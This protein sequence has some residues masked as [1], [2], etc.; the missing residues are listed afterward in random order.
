MSADDTIN[1]QDNVLGGK[2]SDTI[3]GGGGNDRLD[4]DDDINSDVGDD[5]IDG[6]LG[7][8]TLLGSGGNDRLL[9]GAGDDDLSGENGNDRL[10]GGDGIDELDGGNDDD[11]VLG[12]A[13]NDTASGYAGNDVVIGDEGDG[14]SSTATT[15][16]STTRA[17]PT[18]TTPSTA[19]RATTPSTAWRQRPCE[20]WHG[21]RHAERRLRRRHARRRGRGQRQHRRGGFG[22]D[23]LRGG[24]GDDRLTGRA[25]NDDLDG[26]DGNDILGGDSVRYTNLTPPTFPSGAYRVQPRWDLNIGGDDTYDG[27]TGDDFIY[28]V[29]LDPES[30]ASRQNLTVT[31]TDPAD[32]GTSTGTVVDYLYSPATGYQGD[33]QIGFQIKLN[34]SVVNTGTM[35]ISNGQN[36]APVAVDDTAI[37]DRGLA[38]QGNVL[39]NDTDPDGDLL[40]IV[41][42]SGTTS[43][44]TF[45]VVTGGGFTY[46]PSTSFAGATDSFTY[47]VVDPDGATDT[48]TVTVAIRPDYTAPVVACERPTDWSRTEWTVD[49]IAADLASGLADPTRASFELSSALGA[50]NEGPTP[51]DPPVVCDTAGNC[52][53]LEPFDVLVDRK[54]PTI[55]SA[56][57]G[58]TYGLDAEV[59]RE[60]TRTDAGSGLANECYGNGLPLD[61]STAGVHTFIVGA[62]DNVYNTAY[63]TI[64]YTVSAAP[65]ATAPTVTCEQ[66]TTWSAQEWTVHCTSSDTGSGLADAEQA[67]F[68]LV[69]AIGAGNEGSFTI[70]PPTVC[71]VAGN[72]T[73]LTPFDVLVDRKG[74]VVTSTN[75]GA[76]YVQGTAASRQVSCVDTGSG[77]VAS[78]HGW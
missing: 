53:D 29:V 58:Q 74:P 70:D 75:D 15:A 19:V 6:G 42:A 12:G 54:R 5:D 55:T 13:G 22:D 30:A 36:V 46:T 65:D 23:V 2:G 43:G 63:V 34:G 20:R 37:T 31:I 11:E 71:D 35:I 14:P 78:C 60:V 38:V 25:G 50:D 10:S 72:C 52:T 40:D 26:G 64:T 49:C 33:D 47:T 7:N 51:I 39:T 67:A 8:D 45:S 59:V 56:N 24:D 66:P 4:G 73:D 9:G 76:S 27:G 3:F 1:E 62:A 18:A 68:E 69:S 77:L 16:A 21:Q 41:A 61:T 48:G 57:D 44:G 32:H 17:A 28:D